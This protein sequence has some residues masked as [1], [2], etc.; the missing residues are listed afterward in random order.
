MSFRTFLTSAAAAA[1]LSVVPVA[2]QAADW[3]A[4]DVEIILPHAA[5][6]GQDRTTRVLG[7]FWAK[8]LG[9]KFTFNNKKGGSGR[10]GYDYF[11]SKKTDGS[12]IMSSN[13]ASASIMYAQQNPD[14][15]WDE[16]LISLGVFAV[17]PGAIF[18]KANSP[19]QS[20]GEV[21]KEAKAKALTMSV[22]YWASPDN[23]LI[24]Q[25]VEQTGAQ[26]QV[27]PSGGGSKTTTAVI[28]GNVDVGFTKVSNILKAG[29]QVRILALSQPRNV[30]G[31]ATGN[32]PPIDEVLGTDTLDVASYRTINVHKAF[33]EKH[34]EQFELLRETFE[35]TK[36]DPEFIAAAGKAKVQEKLIVDMTP[37]EIAAVVKGHQTAFDT[38]GQV[39][40][41]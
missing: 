10:V 18:V 5:G 28:A 19:Y 25:I 38:Y 29:D 2:S 14:W 16:K 1:M 6:G 17:D 35:A 12:V 32:A 24:H 34:P 13:I 22:A 39:L 26:F 9:A 20:L 31:E 3:Q 33:A 7:E 30:I 27:V 36:D 8:H 23:M 40:T 4:G 21:V 11:L 41:D 15:K 37:K